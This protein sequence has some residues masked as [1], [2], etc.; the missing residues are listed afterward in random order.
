MVSQMTTFKITAHSKTHNKTGI[1]HT[2]V[3][4]L[5]GGDASSISFKPSP[6]SSSK[7]L[8]SEEDISVTFNLD[9]CVPSGI[10]EKR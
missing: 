5:L 10:L 1:Q 8:L 7:R 9:C 6:L 4:L 3:S 2:F